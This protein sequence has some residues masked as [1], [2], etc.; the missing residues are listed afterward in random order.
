MPHQKLIYQNLQVNF[1][2]SALLS[3][4]MTV[5]GSVLEYSVANASN[6][7]MVAVPFVF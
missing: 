3:I 2:I 5:S 4:G 6:D 7:E 1:R